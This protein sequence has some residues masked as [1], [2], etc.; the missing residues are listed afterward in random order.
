M[1]V[2]KGIYVK[3]VS[4]HTPRYIRT[5][6]TGA[7]LK[8]YYNDASLCPKKKIKRIKVCLLSSLDV[9]NDDNIKMFKIILQQ[10]YTSVLFINTVLSVYNS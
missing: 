2:M 10:T 9:V 1:L 3:H 4:S 7:T 5:F 6:E 8:T